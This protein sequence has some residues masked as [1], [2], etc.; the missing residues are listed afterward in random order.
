MKKVNHKSWATFSVTK[1]SDGGMGVKLAKQLLN[2][3]GISTRHGCSPYVGQSGIMVPGTKK[4]MRK[5][6]RILYRS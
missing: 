5:A 6:E 1:V 2:E 4:I 3:A